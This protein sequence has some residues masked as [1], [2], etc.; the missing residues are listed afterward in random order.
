MTTAEREADSVWRRMTK[1]SAAAIAKEAAPSTSRWARAGRGLGKIGRVGFKA[2]GVVAPIAELVGG[3]AQIEDAKAMLSEISKQ[4]EEAYIA[5]MRDQGY[6]PVYRNGKLVDFKFSQPTPSK[7]APSKA[8]TMG[9]VYS[10]R[11]Q[12]LIGQ[13]VPF[14]SD[15]LPISFWSL[16]GEGESILDLSLPVPRMFTGHALRRDQAR[17]RGLARLQSSAVR[18]RRLRSAP[19][20]SASTEAPDAPVAERGTLEIHFYWR[21]GGTEKSIEAVC[22]NTS[23]AEGAWVAETR[24]GSVAELSADMEPNQG[25]PLADYEMDI[26]YTAADGSESQMHLIELASGSDVEEGESPMRFWRWVDTLKARP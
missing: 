14:S 25:E 21:A 20:A 8:P 3:L 23:S 18:L 9:T 26:F 7:P 15:H 13:Q 10:L 16:T 17:L 19:P 11:G 5:V 24:T 1:S 6:E 2:L 22:D 12:R 4:Q